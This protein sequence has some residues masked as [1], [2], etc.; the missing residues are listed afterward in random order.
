MASVCVTSGGFSSWASDPQQCSAHWQ[1]PWQT[2]G[3]H[4]LVHKL[5]LAVM[6]M[7]VLALVPAL[8]HAV[9]HVLVHMFVLAGPVCRHPTPKDM[10]VCWTQSRGAHSVKLHQCMRPSTTRD[11]SR[12]N[13]GM[14]VLGSHECCQ[15]SFTSP[16]QQPMCTAVWQ[17]QMFLRH[18]NSSMPRDMF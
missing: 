9:V 14:H 2:T 1:V 8:V 13:Q 10:A 17:L 6:H 3:V 18:I 16:Q 12:F 7:R 5:V 11:C 4:R 15:A